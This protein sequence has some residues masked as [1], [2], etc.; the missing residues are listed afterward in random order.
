MTIHNTSAAA[1]WIGL[2]SLVLAVACSGSD[3]GAS[4]SQDLLTGGKSQPQ[5]DDHEDG[6]DNVSCAADS[7]CDSDEACV[8]GTCAGTDEDDDDGADDAD[9]ADDEI[10]RAHV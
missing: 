7:D 9:D 1:R 10:G 4:S 3:P 6:D 5:G 8:A 2:A